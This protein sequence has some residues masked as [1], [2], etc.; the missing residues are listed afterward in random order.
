MKVKILKSHSFRENRQI[1]LAANCL[2][3]HDRDHPEV[4]N[5]ESASS[6]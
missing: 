6:H 2:A 1:N 5:T 3:G 4:T